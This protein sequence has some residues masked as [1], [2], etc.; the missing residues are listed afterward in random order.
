MDELGTNRLKVL[1]CVSGFPTS[2]SS[3]VV[4]ESFTY[5]SQNSNVVLFMEKCSESLTV[6]F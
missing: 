2:V 3:V 4:L 5:F 1:F 6:I